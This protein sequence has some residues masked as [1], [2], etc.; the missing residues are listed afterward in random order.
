MHPISE[1]RRCW[2]RVVAT[3]ETFR[4]LTA[5]AALTDNA[6]DALCRGCGAFARMR[7]EVSTLDRTLEPDVHALDS[8]IVCEPTALDLF[9]G[10]TRSRYVATVS[11]SAERI[12]THSE[13]LSTLGWSAEAVVGHD[14]LSFLD[15]R[16]ATATRCSLKELTP[17]H[18]TFTGRG[19]IRRA[20]GAPVWVSHHTT[21]QY[22]DATLI[23]LQTVAVNVLSVLERDADAANELLYTLCSSRREDIAILADDW[24]VLWSSV[25]HVPDDDSDSA[26]AYQRFGLRLPGRTSRVAAPSGELWID[27]TARHITAAEIVKGLVVSGRLVSKRDD[28]AVVSGTPAAAEPALEDLAKRLRSL[29]LIDRARLLAELA[30]NE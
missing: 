3:S 17:E 21:G 27:L 9:H 28:L 25:R 14:L 19:K 10:T 24:N 20:D 5:P 26:A 15:D 13:G 8:V 18:P 29:S 7:V 22:S 30:H 1:S 16:F 11:W 6:Q 12:I 2:G 4:R 23:N